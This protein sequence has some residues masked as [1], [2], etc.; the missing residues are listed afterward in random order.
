MTHTFSRAT[1]QSARV[2]WAA[3]LENE[4]HI[5]YK[6]PRQS[7]HVFQCRFESRQKGAGNVNVRLREG[8]MLQVRP[9]GRQVILMPPTPSWLDPLLSSSPALLRPALRV[10]LSQGWRDFQ[11]R[12]F[13][14]NRGQ[15][16]PLQPGPSQTWPRRGLPFQGRF[17]S[18]GL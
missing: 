10:A 2:P 14:A 1:S 12:S 13:L 8:P 6:N 18:V 5:N 4:L 15:G 3:L 9:Q 11:G 16:S 7:P 17:P